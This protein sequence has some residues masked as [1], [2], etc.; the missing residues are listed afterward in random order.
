MR[1]A[2]IVIAL[3]ATAAHADPPKYTRPKAEAPPV[4]LSDRT[5]PIEPKKIVDHPLTGSDILRIEED[6][7]P[8]RKQQELVLARLAANT[9]DDDP[10]KAD[11]LFRLAELYA[12]QSR[13]WRLKTF[14][15]EK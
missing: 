7:Q 2:L 8:I 4:K 5:K 10:D 3:G 11:I 13:F 9:P 1:T 6:R 14:D 15:D 12:K